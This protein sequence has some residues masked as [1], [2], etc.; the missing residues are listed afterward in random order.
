MK[1]LLQAFFIYVLCN[2][3]DIGHPFPWVPLPGNPFPWVPDDTPPP[4]LLYRGPP[5]YSII[6][7]CPSILVEFHDFAS[8]KFYT[9]FCTSFVVCSRLPELK[10]NLPQDCSF[11]AETFCTKICVCTADRIFDHD[12]TTLCRRIPAYF[13]LLEEGWFHRTGTYIGNVYYAPLNPICYFGGLQQWETIS[14]I[15]VLEPVKLEHK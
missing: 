14:R 3:R 4:P 9:Y 7:L 15:P 1:N 13:L 2:V 11:K 12:E 10:R 8:L 5:D 6:S